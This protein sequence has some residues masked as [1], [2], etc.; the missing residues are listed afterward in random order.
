GPELYVGTFQVDPQLLKQAIAATDTGIFDSITGLPSVAT[1]SE[2][3]TVATD[4]EGGLKFVTRTNSSA[5]AAM[6][7][8]IRF[9]QVAGVD[10]RP[11]TGKSIFWSDGS[12][13]LMVRATTQDLDMIEAI[14]QSLN[15]PT[16]SE[17]DSPSA[18]SGMI[19]IPNARAITPANDAAAS[20]N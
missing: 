11:E 1:G 2:G 6:A 3:A 19:R 14:L 20:T 9:F 12:G 18:A 13:R 15:L 5:N 17:T 16:S 8:M 7:G 10:L 4:R